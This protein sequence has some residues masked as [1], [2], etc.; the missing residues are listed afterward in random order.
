MRSGDVEKFAMLEIVQLLLRRQI[1]DLKALLDLPQS[2]ESTVRTT[3]ITYVSC[4]NVNY[5]EEGVHEE[6]PS[7]ISRRSSQVSLG[8]ATS[9]VES[10][11]LSD[12][13]LDFDEDKL[14]TVDG[15]ESRSGFVT[16]Y[17]GRIRLNITPSILVLAFYY[18]EIPLHASDLY[19]LIQTGRLSYYNVSE[20]IPKEVDNMLTRTQKSVLS[21]PLIIDSHSLGKATCQLARLMSV[22]HSVDN[23]VL[24]VRLLLW[25]IGEDLS[26]P[27][28]YR[29]DLI[30]LS[31]KLGLEYR[32]GA[33]VEKGS[34]NALVTAYVLVIFYLKL[35]YGMFD[36]TLSNRENE[37]FVKSGLPTQYQ[38][39]EAW[40]SKL[41]HVEDP[42]EF[43]SSGLARDFEFYQ[44]HVV[45]PRIEPGDEMEDDL[46]QIKRSLRIDALLESARENKGGAP[47][48][49]LD[50]ER[51]IEINDT[52]AKQ[53]PCSLVKTKEPKGKEENRG[54]ATWS[55]A[56]RIL[57]KLGSRF[58]CCEDAHLEFALSSLFETN[59]ASLWLHSTFQS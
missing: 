24:D 18:H 57:L 39:L 32:F 30:S 26:L 54:F 28:I 35:H 50:P 31:V 4:L 7:Q 27:Y 55:E 49:K 1:E 59:A 33:V 5:E 29:E 13:D 12:D 47:W 22:K 56:Y 15:T 44:K 48:L 45:G 41:K 17:A 3:W 53:Y 43:T 21:N 6:L 19:R 40:R 34:S 36:S 52:W 58:C 9:D 38:L 23:P 11:K 16:P 51:E 37:N 46:A 20:L 14:A 8:L 25:R 10:T 2:F 42:Q